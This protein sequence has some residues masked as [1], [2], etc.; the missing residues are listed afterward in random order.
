M[1]VSGSGR[2]TGQPI[3]EGRMRGMCCRTNGGGRCVERRRKASS[4]AGRRPEKAE[5][6]VAL[7][8]RVWEDVGSWQLV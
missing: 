2:G 6:P 8:M 4:A 7:A 3:G 1:R 5:G